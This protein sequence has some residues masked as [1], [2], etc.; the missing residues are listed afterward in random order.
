V[1][2]EDHSRA[3][4]RVKVALSQNLSRKS[5]VEVRRPILTPPEAV[6]EI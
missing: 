6:R 5:R 4:E 3:K 1:P 2:V